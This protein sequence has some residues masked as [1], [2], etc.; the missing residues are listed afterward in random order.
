MFSY[1]SAH[2]APTCA[3]T[4][5]LS[6]VY[7]IDKHF[8]FIH[9]VRAP[10]IKVEFSMRSFLKYRHL[11]RTKLHFMSGSARFS[12]RLIHSHS[13]NRISS[14]LDNQNQTN[15]PQF[16]KRIWLGFTPETDVKIWAHFR[17]GTDWRKHIYYF[18]NQIQFVQFTDSNSKLTQ[19]TFGVPKGNVLAPI[20]YLVYIYDESLS[21]T[22]K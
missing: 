6:F 21:F 13:T 10:A 16:F 15:L 5:I 14:G 11:P 19:V 20:L 4:P 9:H 18:T 17:E 8:L 1:R 7:G 12:Q 2:D 3:R 22:S